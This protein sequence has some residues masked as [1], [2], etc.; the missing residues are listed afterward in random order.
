MLRIFLPVL[1]APQ[2]LQLHAS[3][4]L[5]SSLPFPIASGHLESSYSAVFWMDREVLGNTLNYILST[6]SK[7]QDAQSRRI[8]EIKQEGWDLFL[9][10]LGDGSIVVT[11]VAVSTLLS[12]YACL[13]RRA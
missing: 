2:L 9:R 11:A 7:D 5:F 3:L 4:D 6:R 8:A 1:D 13:K 12:L 10:V